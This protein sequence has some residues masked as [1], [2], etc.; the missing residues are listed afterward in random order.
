MDIEFNW[1]AVLLGGLQA[2]SDLNGRV[3]MVKVY[4]P[5]PRRWRVTLVKNHDLVKFLHTPGYDHVLSASGETVAVK[6]QN[7]ACLN[8]RGL[9]ED[10]AYF[11]END[12][13]FDGNSDDADDFDF[14]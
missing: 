5:S 10:T 8:I 6:E 12:S 14:L 3:A 9:H 4:L 2:R 1:K 13:F 7:L 11:P